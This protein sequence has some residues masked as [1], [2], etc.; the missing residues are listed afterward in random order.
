MTPSLKLLRDHQNDRRDRG[1]SNSRNDG[2]VYNATVAYDR[3]VD[4][5]NETTVAK[6]MMC[7]NINSN[8]GENAKYVCSEE[9]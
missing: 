1:G 8:S 4:G 6:S 2:S 9:I 7:F 5:T 3:E